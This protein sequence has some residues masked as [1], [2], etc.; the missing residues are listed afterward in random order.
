MAR[1]K[2][3][4]AGKPVKSS[5]FGVSKVLRER[6]RPSRPLPPR[7]DAT[8]EEMAKAMFRLP[9]DY[10]WQYEQDGGTTY[11]CADCG[12]EVSYPET[13][14]NDGLCEEC[15]ADAVN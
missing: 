9:A 5:G 1:T 2:H 4:K 12:R 11:R 10:Q 15:H 7:I 6:G 14:Y 8:P 13:L 3:R